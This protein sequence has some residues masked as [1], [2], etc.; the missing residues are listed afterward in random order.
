MVIGVG[1]GPAQGSE[2]RSSSVGPETALE[3]SLIQTCGFGRKKPGVI[4][5]P[6]V[7]SRLPL[8]V[9]PPISTTWALAGGARQVARQTM[10]REAATSF[11]T[12]HLRCLTKARSKFYH[13]RWRPQGGR[14]AYRALAQGIESALQRRGQVSRLVPDD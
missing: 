2:L 5:T 14:C 12:R 9:E 8:L 13:W 3:A 7:R 11:M 10:S 4:S 1:A 6:K